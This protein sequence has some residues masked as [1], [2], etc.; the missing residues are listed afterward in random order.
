M[1]YLVTGGAGFI[2]SHLCEA[3]ILEGHEV[4]VLD[5]LSTG[6][7]QNLPRGAVLHEGCI[8]DYKLIRQL[9]TVVD[10]VFHLAAIASVT[11]SLEEWP[12]THLINQS[13]AV[14][15][16][17]AAARNGVPVVY[18]SSAAVYGECDTLPL[19][20]DVSTEPLSPYGLDKLACEWQAKIGARIKGLRSV[21]L[22]FFNVFGPRQD[23]KSPYSGVIS[24]F[25]D[26]LKLRQSLSVFG[27][28]E[29]TRDF[30]YVGD[31][32]RALMLSMQ[33]LMQESE[34]WLVC[35]V[36]TGKRISVNELAR[37][38]CE[39]GDMEAMTERL[40]KREG[41]ILHSCG[42]PEK[43]KRELNFEAEVSLKDGLIAL[44]KSIG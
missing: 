13:G 33:R 17:N 11:R 21:G 15:V 31:V 37:Q 6:K 22:R 8:T 4:I 40:P 19:T 36:C 3:L 38:L 39:A 2:G 43:A 27:D 28:G 35:N 25:A 9:M 7:R 5:D 42:N 30:I 41:D 20:E 24:I 16:M 32:A 14:E 26:K 23:P 18:A 10:G 1:K 29:Q 44:W 34:L 12:Q